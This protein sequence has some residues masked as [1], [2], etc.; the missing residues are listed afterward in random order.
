MGREFVVVIVAILWFLSISSGCLAK[1]DSSSTAIAFVDKICNDATYKNLCLDTLV[2][3]AD[4]IG[5]VA[6]KA[7]RL[8]ITRTVEEVQ[9]M[10]SE[11]NSLSNPPKYWHREV[12]AFVRCSETISRAGVDLFSALEVTNHLGGGDKAAKETKRLRME[13]NVKSVINDTQTCMDFLRNSKAGNNIINILQYNMKPIVQL[14]TNAIDLIH[15]LHGG[16]VAVSS[17]TAGGVGAA[18]AEA[19]K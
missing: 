19:P 5:G 1:E 11:L 8:A 13:N 3:Y 7:T 9:S 17:A 15:H 16:A 14:A 10:L 18:A 4:R 6:K 12:T 2:P